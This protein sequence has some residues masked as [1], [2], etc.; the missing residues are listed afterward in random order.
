MKKAAKKFH[1]ILKEFQ[2]LENKTP[3]DAPT[4]L[5]ILDRLLRDK[6]VSADAIR[7]AYDALVKERAQDAA[8]N[9]NSNNNRK[10]STDDNNTQQVIRTRHVALEIF[11]D[12]EKYSGL[13]ENV[14]QEKDQSIERA[15]FQALQK[16]QF[17]TNRESAQYSRCGRTD[18]GVSAA[19]QVVALHVKSAF[20]RHASWDAQGQDL[21]QDDQL[22]KNSIDLKTVWVLPRKAKKGKAV[23]GKVVRQQ[24]ELTEFAYDHVLNNLLPPEIRVLGWTPVSDDF[25]ARF[26]AGSRTYRYFFHRRSMSID[27]MREGLAY[28]VGTHDFRNL[29]KLN[30]EEVSN[31]ERKIHE[32]KIVPLT[33]DGSDCLYRL[34]I[35]GQAFLWHQ[36]RCIV[37][38]LFMIGKG[39]EE[40]QVVEELLDVQKHPG[41]PAY[42][43]ADEKPLVLHDCA[44][45]NLQFGC[46]IRNLW[47]V[48][49]HQEKRWE[50]LVLAAARIRNSLDKMGA[51]QLQASDVQRFCVEKLELRRKKADKGGQSVAESN[52]TVLPP[53]STG[54]TTW[55]EALK[56]M[57]TVGLF[58]EPDSSRD[59]VHT[60]LLQRS[61]GTSYEDKV[62]S[63]QSN[64]KRKG[65][66]EENMNKKS[67]SKEEDQAFYDH[68]AKQGGSAFE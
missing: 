41:K 18:K 46:T 42:P 49:C 12:G 16:C 4:A 36:I 30:V 59:M 29:C 43:L 60:P 53:F 22:P 23:D 61:K 24:K 5:E 26:S 33:G 63:L 1:P 44:Y 3:K 8:A 45:P 15:L 10:V 57:E 7:S 55:K 6:S 37:S 11:Y 40:P 2:L 27:K 13:A 19:G 20:G 66:F 25:S 54:L 28:M 68:K 56:W 58:P 38:I 21:V 17:I 67:K 32:A 65:R 14:G 52:D 64:T 62:A 31:F 39:L 9:N 48:T 51:S 35:V 50:D 47:T 34:Q